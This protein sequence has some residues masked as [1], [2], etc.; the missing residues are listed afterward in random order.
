MQR[1]HASQRG[2]CL[3]FGDAAQQ[4]RS[5][6][7]TGRQLFALPRSSD[8]LW[9]DRRAASVCEAHVRTKLRLRTHE[10]VAIQPPPKHRFLVA[11]ADVRWPLVDQWTRRIKAIEDS[12]LRVL[13]RQASLAGELHCPC[14]SVHLLIERLRGD[15][16]H[17]RRGFKLAV[18]E[19]LLPLV[20]GLLWHKCI[21]VNVQI[22]DEFAEI[23]FR[24]HD[25]HPQPRRSWR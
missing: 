3:R 22:A 4:W 25:P 7:L 1:R 17:R 2:R 18:F 8:I 5:H 11:T 24:T 10:P 6:D 14:A 21:A 13:V 16:S 19:G 20:G 9:Q 23:L 15:A 12:K